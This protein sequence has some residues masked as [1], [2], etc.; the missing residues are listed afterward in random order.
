MKEAVVKLLQKALKKEKVEINPREIERLI[1][2]PPSQDMGDYA[3]P[4]FILVDKIKESPSQIAMMLREHM[5]H[6]KDFQDIQTV[7]PYINFFVNRTLFAR[8]LIKQ[9]LKEKE[10]FGKQKTGEG[11][12]TMIEFSQPNTHKAFHVGHIRG[13]SLGESLAR[14]LEFCGE[15]V[16][17]VNYMGDT[18]MHI[19]KWLWCYK[20]YHHREKL[21]RDEAWIASIYVDAVKRL[22]SH[23]TL[24]KE[25]DEINRKLATGEDRHLNALWKKTREISLSAFKKIYKQLNT[26]FDAYFFESEV[27]KR[28]KEIVDDLL[29]RKIARVS[30]GAVVINLKKYDLGVWVLLRKDRTIL[31]PTK[32]LALAELKFRRYKLDRNIYVIG[33]AQT[34]HM[35][36]LFKTLH[37]MKFPEA[38]KNELISFSEV[39]LP[40]GKMSSRTGENVLYTHFLKEIMDYSKKEIKKRFSSLKKGELQ[41][42][43]L[44]ISMAAMKYSMLKQSANKNIIFRKS[45]ALNFD[46]DSGPYVL[47]SFARATSILKKAARRKSLKSSSKKLKTPKLEPKEI[48]L[49]KKLYQF[50]EIVS[51]SYENM[52]STVIANYSYQ[53]AQIFNEFYHSSPVLKS[54]HENFRISLVKAF[55]QVLGNSLNLLGIEPLDEM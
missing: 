6:A 16:K 25:V 30:D 7:G 55:R 44:K 10:R 24:Q 33:A 15:E 29:K 14:I 51:N 48:E 50:P 28:G 12:N 54:K 2:T 20:K 8:D 26:H 47:Y 46:G 19:A 49:V 32:D 41:E 38:P 52:N 13:T 18:G 42:R 5:T 35:K 53:L 17:R 23:K 40:Q 45:E 27:E 36:Q 1:E 21:K 22:E 34:L 31:Y 11:K 43:A 37:L 3:F 4:C 39:R 9:I